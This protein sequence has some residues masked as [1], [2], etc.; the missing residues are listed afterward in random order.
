M[1]KSYKQYTKKVYIIV[2]LT[3]AKKKD[4]NTPPGG[5]TQNLL[6]RSQTRCHYASRAANFLISVFF[7]I[8]GG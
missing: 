6:I 3:L 2:L 5:R 7:K 8:E 1:T 4:I